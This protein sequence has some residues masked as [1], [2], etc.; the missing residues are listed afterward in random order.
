V[1]SMFDHPGFIQYDNG[2]IEVL[3][4][5]WPV[6][7]AGHGWRVA[8]QSLAVFP[9]KVRF[10]R[11]DD[12]D[13]CYLFVAVGTGPCLE[14]VGDLYE[15][16]WFHVAVW[17]ADLLELH[18]RGLVSGLSFQ[19]EYEAALAYY[20]KHKD[21]FVEIDGQLRPLDL[22]RPEIDDYDEE[23]PTVPQISADGIAVTGAS[24][25][26]LVMIARPLSEIGA[27]IRQRAEPL[28]SISFYDTAVREAGIILESRLR[29]V[30][31][32]TNF[33]QGLVDEYYKLLCARY[34]GN[35]RA[36]FKILRSELRT[37][38]KFVRNDFA[39]A[40]HDITKD[41]CH[42]LL[43]RISTALERINEIELAEH[44]E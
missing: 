5:D 30:T 42:V 19:T 12:I 3:H 28:V 15:G 17:H 22:P 14:P 43:D 18:E 20:E 36:I 37:I 23:R 9:A 44:G 8:L 33:G 40:L 26:A 29:E 10:Q 31:G 39:H 34:Q 35:P 38:F 4:A 21:L 24:A 25:D 2:N 16:R 11:L 13:Q 7:P 6:Y 1:S 32:S 41:Q 27:A